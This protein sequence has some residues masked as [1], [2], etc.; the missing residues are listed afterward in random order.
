MWLVYRASCRNAILSEALL[1]I[2]QSA[3]I[4]FSMRCCDVD[5]MLAMFL[6][7]QNKKLVYHKELFYHRMPNSYILCCTNP[8]TPSSSFS[9]F[10]PSFFFSCL[11]FLSSP[12]HPYL[13]SSY[14]PPP[15]YPPPICPLFS[16]LLSIKNITVE[17]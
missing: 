15:N 5:E 11:I 13:P 7:L 1:G 8:P 3:Q 2:E 10:L 9:F 14:L 12:H 16:R 6:S 4:D 17:V